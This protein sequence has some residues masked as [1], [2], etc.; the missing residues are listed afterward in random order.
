MA[1]A[2]SSLAPIFRFFF[3][4][5]DNQPSS[6]VHA[7]LKFREYGFTTGHHVSR[8]LVECWQKHFD[9]CPLPTTR[10]R[11]CKCGALQSPEYVAKLNG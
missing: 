4:F 10:P 11:R 8:H 3:Y 2:I 9:S 5:A 6:A 7:S 1:A